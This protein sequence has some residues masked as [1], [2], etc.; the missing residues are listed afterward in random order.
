M[1]EIASETVN[2]WGFSGNEQFHERGWATGACT[3]SSAA[4]YPAVR[5][6]TIKAAQSPGPLLQRPFVIFFL[7]FAV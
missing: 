7:Y 4:I 1:S 2:I 6:A 3:Q 5:M